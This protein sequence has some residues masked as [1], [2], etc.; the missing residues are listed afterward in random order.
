MSGVSGSEKTGKIVNFVVDASEP[1]IYATCF[2]RPELVASLQSSAI[3]RTTFGRPDLVEE[4][5]RR[6]DPDRLRR[7]RFYAKRYERRGKHVKKAGGN[8]R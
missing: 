3:D 1:L 5:G 2:V 6:V 4:L 8:R 7:L